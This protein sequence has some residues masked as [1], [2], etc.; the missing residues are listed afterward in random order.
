MS[1]HWTP[2][3]SPF[4]TKSRALGGNL[5]GDENKTIPETESEHINGFNFIMK[6]KAHE[7]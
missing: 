6:L 3:L 2:D 4:I 1:G 5:K 7:S